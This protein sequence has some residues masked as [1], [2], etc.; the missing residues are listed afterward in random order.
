VWGVAARASRRVAPAFALLTRSTNG[1]LFGSLQQTTYEAQWSR[2]GSET[3]MEKFDNVLRRNVAPQL[4]GLPD[5]PEDIFLLIIDN[6]E[7]WDFVQSRKVSKSWRRAFSEPEYLRLMLKK[8]SFAREVRDFPTN[9]AFSNP[10]Q[11]SNVDWRGIF[12]QIAARYFHLTHGRARSITKYKSAVPEHVRLAHWYPVS[13]WEYHNSQPGARLYHQSPQAL[14]EHHP[15]RPGEQAYLF[16]PSFWSYEDGL[17][18]YS[19][20]RQPEYKWD[21]RKNITVPVHLGLLLV[22]LEADAQYPIPFDLTKRVIRN[23]RLKERTLI[24]EWAE[25]TSFH[26]LNDL[27][28]VHRHYASCYDIALDSSTSD[29]PRHWTITFRSEFKLHFLGLPLNSRD[30]FFSIHTRTHYLI[31]IWQPNRSMYTGDEELPIESLIVWDI[32]HPSKYLPSLDPTGRHKPDPPFSPK[33]PCGP[34]VIAKFSFRDLEHFGIRQHGAISLMS[35]TLDSDAETITVRENVRVSGQGEGYF[36]PAERLWCARTTSF[37]IC[38]QGPHLRRE[39]DGNLPPYR[40]NGSM[41]TADVLEAEKWFLGIMDVVDEAAK[42]RFSLVETVF[43]GQSMENQKLL[44]VEALGES[45]VALNDELSREICHMGRI[46]GDERFLVGQN[47]NQEVVV[48]RF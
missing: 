1:R 39:W 10:A 27:E 40:G 8:Y 33:D 19:P 13:P 22:D 9:G 6:L 5:L 28:R 31:Y 20:P 38:A 29:T 12:D 15:R 18:V 11:A 45:P 32:S 47:A 44:R 17:L 46:A 30:R 35:F 48:L 24:I 43:T 7:A 16:R 21:A 25:E 4:I 2:L 14:Y 3:S 36:D 34:Y 37:P 41:E 26:A 23:F 42:V